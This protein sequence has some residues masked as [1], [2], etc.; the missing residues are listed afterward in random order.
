MLQLFENCI[1]VLAQVSDTE[2]K[3]MGTASEEGR[4][5]PERWV[6]HETQKLHESVL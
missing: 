3:D 5:I 6:L 1:E 4:R 2:D